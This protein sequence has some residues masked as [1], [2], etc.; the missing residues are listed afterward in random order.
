MQPQCIPSSVSGPQHT[1]YVV[2]SVVCLTSNSNSR[3]DSD[4]FAVL[5]TL[6][7]LLGFL[8][9][10]WYEYFAFS[11]C[12]L[13]CH[14][15]L[16]SLGGLIISELDLGERGDGEVAVVEMHYVREEP[17]FITIKKINLLK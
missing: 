2:C 12:I 3:H 13:S 16:L 4:S 5:G 8:A 1:R 6:L 15:C 11:Y 14:V 10:P 17:I 7:L 9:Q